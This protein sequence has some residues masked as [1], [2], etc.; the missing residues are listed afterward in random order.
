MSKLEGL[1]HSPLYITKNLK[2]DKWFLNQNNYRN[3]HFQSLNNYKRKYKEDISNQVS[4]LPVF[5][6]VSVTLTV[7]ARDKRLFDLDNTAAVHLKFFLDALVEAKKLPEDDY[8]YVPEIH[9]YFGSICK[10]D[11]R[12]DILVKELE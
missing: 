7:Y 6:K 3:T 12:V 9:T 2:G 8:T 4:N 11:P 5:S 1:V 10:E